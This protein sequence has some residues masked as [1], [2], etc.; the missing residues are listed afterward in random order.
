[1]LANKTF[2]YLDVPTTDVLTS[3][4]QKMEKTIIHRITGA[5]MYTRMNQLHEILSKTTLDKIK[6]IAKKLKDTYT[7]H[8]NTL[9]SI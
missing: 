6:D 5:D 9:I 4:C 8:E 1:M 3:S 2:D 7:E